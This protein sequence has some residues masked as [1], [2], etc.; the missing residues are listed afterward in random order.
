MRLFAEFICITYILGALVSFPLFTYE[1]YE[2]LIEHST[3]RAEIHEDFLFKM[4][5]VC[6]AMVASTC[7]SVIWPVGLVIF[8]S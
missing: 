8:L 5:S 6:V 4:I 1:A 7:F 2:N 3:S